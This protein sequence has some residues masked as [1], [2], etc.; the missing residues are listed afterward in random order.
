MGK[1][2]SLAGAIGV[3]LAALTVAPAAAA[4]SCEIGEVCAIG[5]V[6]IA[7]V[8]EVKAAIADKA[9][10]IV[11]PYNSTESILPL[12]SLAESYAKQYDLNEVIFVGKGT[13]KDS[14]DVYSKSDEAKE[15]KLLKALN[16]A[17]KSD[18]G[19]AL[20]AANVG[21]FYSQ[22]MAIQ[23]GDDAG[24]GPLA[25]LIPGAVLLAAAGAGVGFLMRKRRRPEVAAAHQ[26]AK[27][28]RAAD[29]SVQLSD[30]LRTELNGLSTTADRY[31][32]SG[33]GELIEASELA[34]IVLTHIYE[35]FRR[36]D[37]KGSR[38]YRELAQIRYLD[39]VKKLNS[40]LSE[41][42]FEYIVKSPSF[43]E[44]SEEKKTAVLTA[45]RSVDRQIIENIK[46]VNSSKE[47]EFKVAVDSLI[48]PTGPT[49]EDTFGEDTESKQTKWS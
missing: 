3:L 36:I 32:R 24:A 26:A 19:E 4:T 29:K 25:L 17:G 23:T 41:D 8:S 34:S 9:T 33:N 39:I 43:W 44:N 30:E 11:A 10:V 16:S 6:S 12:S 7:K 46:Q 22:P 2:L 42:Y 14:F 35:L 28:N 48:G 27:A 20:V 45:L 47:I 31:R 49:I 1:R 15:D 21:S 37:R 5:S 13:T 38:Q 40:A 18:G